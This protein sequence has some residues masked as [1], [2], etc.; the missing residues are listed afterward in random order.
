MRR[1]L[2]IA[3]ILLLG[4]L[5]SPVAARADMPAPGGGSDFG[6]HVASMTP[7]HPRDHGPMFGNCVSMLAT[8]GSCQH[9]SGC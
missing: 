5:A 9:N 3:G 2:V 8:T 7:D 4:L 1:S 6:Q